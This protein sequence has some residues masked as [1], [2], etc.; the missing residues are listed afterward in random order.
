[1]TKAPAR[2]MRPAQSA[3]SDKGHAPG[4]NII[5]TQGSGTFF[6]NW[7]ARD[8]KILLLVTG[9]LVLGTATFLIVRHVVRKRRGERV[10]RRSVIDGAPEKFAQ[11]LV[12]AMDGAGTDEEAVFETFSKMPSLHFYTR[13]A[14]AYEDH[15]DGGI[16]ADDLVGDLDKED[17][18]VVMNILNSKPKRDRGEPSYHLLSDWTQRMI[19]AYEGAGTDEDAIYRVLYEVPDKNGFAL[20]NEEFKKHT[21]GYSMFDMLTEEMEGDDLDYARQIMIEKPK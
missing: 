17:L 6:G 9:G 16:L 21:D 4:E 14:K 18:R 1:M 20:L 8:K 12:N 11:E 19:N 10:Q 2:A 5:I 3:S 15:P 13:V 7:S